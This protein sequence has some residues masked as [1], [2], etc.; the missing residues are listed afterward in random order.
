MKLR[1]SHLKKEAREFFQKQ[2]FVMNTYN[3]DLTDFVKVLEEWTMKHIRENQNN[4]EYSRYLPKIL[5]DFF[6]NAKGTETKVFNQTLRFVVS[7]DLTIERLQK[8]YDYVDLDQDG[9][10]PVRI[11]L[12]QAVY[13]R[14]VMLYASQIELS[15]KVRMSDT[16]LFKM[17]HLFSKI[18]TDS[19]LFRKNHGTN[20]HEINAFLAA[21]IFEEIKD[22][23]IYE[24]FIL[25]T[26]TNEIKEK[27]QHLVAIYDERGMFKHSYLILDDFD[28]I[29]SA[30]EILMIKTHCV[31]KTFKIFKNLM[32]RNSP[33]LALKLFLQL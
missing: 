6:A 29:V 25:N 12:L 19:K 21:A 22:F 3:S 20:Y 33:K 11:E 13:D 9:I 4:Y 17:T 30:M 26:E 8:T 5:E 28:V 2:G 32:E 27:L 15:N 10:Y 14:M 24:D 7:H 18:K 16:A 1:V 31:D 23:F